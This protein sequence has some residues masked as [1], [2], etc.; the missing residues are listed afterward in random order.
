MTEQL[1]D[2]EYLRDRYG[3]QKSDRSLAWIVGGVLTVLAL[4]WTVWWA[5]SEAQPTIVTEEAALRVESN[6]E[7]YVTFNVTAPQG[8]TVSCTVRAVTDNLT[9]VGVKEVSIGPLTE[10]SVSVTTL[11]ATIQPATGASVG[12][13]RFLTQ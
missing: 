10:E 11:V 9:E 4:A 7:V 3:S 13:C 12:D 8:S 6:A 5:I 2:S 1:S